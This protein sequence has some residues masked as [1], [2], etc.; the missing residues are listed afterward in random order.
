MS[1]LDCHISVPTLIVEGQ[2]DDLI[3]GSNV[4]KHFIRV[5]KYSEN[6]CEKMSLSNDSSCDEKS[7]LQL[8]GGVE[9][10]RDG[11]PPDK[12]GTV[13]LQHA[14]TLEPL[15]EHLVWGCLPKQKCL[16]AGSTVVVEPTDSRTV[17]RTV[18]VGRLVT[19]LWGDGWVPVRLSTPP[20]NQ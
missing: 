19:P 16:S 17:L 5:H 12:V 10:W 1:V 11:D 20:T 15:K 9:T 7:L 8:L 6:F 3:L 2:T 13:K 18:L 4:I 14:V